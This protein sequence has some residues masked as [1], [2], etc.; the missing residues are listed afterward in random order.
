MLNFL[1]CCEAVAHDDADSIRKLLKTGDS[2]ISDADDNIDAA[3]GLVKK[4]KA[5]VDSL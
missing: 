1:A 5:Y 3:K 2:I 4:I